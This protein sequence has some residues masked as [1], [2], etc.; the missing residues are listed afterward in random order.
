MT[1]EPCVSVCSWQCLLNSKQ[2]TCK[3]W[4]QNWLLSKSVRWVSCGAVASH[5]PGDKVKVIRVDCLRNVPSENSRMEW[6]ILHEIL[7]GSTFNFPLH[8]LCVSS[9]TFQL[10]FAASL[11]VEHL[12][13][14]WSDQVWKIQAENGSVSALEG[15]LSLADQMDNPLMVSDLTISV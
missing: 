5:L 4:E 6:V 13:S 12:L 15:A 1:Y 2:P 8:S 7:A 11:K 14:I 3:A 9:L 10:S